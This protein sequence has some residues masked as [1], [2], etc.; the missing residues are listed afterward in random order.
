MYSLKRLPNMF[1]YVDPIIVD[2]PI[3]DKAVAF[4][5]HDEVTLLGRLDRVDVFRGYLDNCW[6][7]SGLRSDGWSWPSVSVQ[8]AADIDLV[9][10]RALSMKGKRANR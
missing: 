10:P 7:E 4:Q 2:T 3:L 1:A 5:I 9:R 8:L 6:L